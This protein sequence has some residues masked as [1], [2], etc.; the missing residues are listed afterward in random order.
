MEVLDNRKDL[1]HNGA[2]RDHIY[3]PFN[4]VW[5]EIKIFRTENE[6]T[7]HPD[8]SDKNDLSTVIRCDGFFRRSELTGEQNCNYLLAQLNISASVLRKSFF[9]VQNYG[10][11]LREV[12]DNVQRQNASARILITQQFGQQHHQL[13]NLQQEPHQCFQR[14][15]LFMIQT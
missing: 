8:S 12:S 13:Y 2:A 9:Q 7:A 11:N 10:G 1:V 14:A 6:E 5:N 15:N 4:E 3:D